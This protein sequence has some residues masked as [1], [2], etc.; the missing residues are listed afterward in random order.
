VSKSLS[1]YPVAPQFGGTGAIIAQV[2]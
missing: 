2:F 1:W